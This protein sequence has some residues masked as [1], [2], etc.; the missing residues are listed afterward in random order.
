MIEVLTIFNFFIIVIYLFIQLKSFE[1]SFLKY[2]INR[3]KWNSI[4][5]FISHNLKYNDNNDQ[6]KILAHCN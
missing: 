4:S 3:R 1:A 2:I 5:I 6:K